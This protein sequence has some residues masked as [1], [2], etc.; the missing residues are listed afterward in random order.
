MT[1]LIQPSSS[2]DSEIESSWVADALL[3][4]NAPDASRTYC[5]YV[6][7]VHFEPRDW[8]LRDAYVSSMAIE[9]FEKAWKWIRSEEWKAYYQ[10]DRTLGEPPINERE[11]LLTVLLDQILKPQPRRKAIEALT[12]APMDASDEQFLKA[13]LLDPASDLPSQSFDILQDLLTTR[14]LS[15]GQYSSA[16]DLDRR[17]MDLV[18]STSSASSSREISDGKV[19]RERRAMIG[20]MIS[21]LPRVQREL[22]EAEKVFEEEDMEDQARGGTSWTNA[23]TSTLTTQQHASSSTDFAPSKRVVSL[24]GLIASS[25]SRNRSSPKAPSAMYQAILQNHANSVKTSDSH[26]LSQSQ[27]RDSRSSTPTAT[28]HSPFVS[29]PQRFTPKAIQ[30]TRHQSPFSS[31][32]KMG[33]TSDSPS[34]RRQ[35][36]IQTSALVDSTPQ[37]QKAQSMSS[38]TDSTPVARHVRNKAPLTHHASESSKLVHTDPDQLSKEEDYDMEV[39]ELALTDETNTQSGQTQSLASES[40]PPRRKKSVRASLGRRGK[41]SEQVTDGRAKAT[42][43]RQVS[44]AESVA[45]SMDQ[46]EDSVDEKIASDLDELEGEE[47]DELATQASQVSSVPTPEPKRSRKRK[48]SSALHEM[49]V[50][51]VIETPSKKAR[52]GKSKAVRSKDFGVET[53]EPSSSVAPPK[54]K[55]TRRTGSKVTPSAPEAELAPPVKRVARRTTRSQSV[56]STGSTDLGDD[57]PEEDQGGRRKLRRSSRLS[58]VA[59]T[60]PTLSVVSEFDTTMGSNNTATVTTAPT[61]RKR[62]TRATS[63][64]PSEPPSSPCP[65]ARRRWS[66]P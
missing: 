41:P 37:R 59:P 46:D 60:S 30:Q 54:K 18:R 11:R 51:V 66:S 39:D 27:N 4:N 36:H 53:P 9:N 26:R 5:R 29:I 32:I 8:Q 28:S 13:Y 7:F 17:V 10:D 52:G 58:S 25:A 38:P 56:L 15:Q 14:Y 48:D 63:R 33:S 43:Q 40:T 23:S 21:L 12:T 19:R 44:A 22:L 45:E 64:Q 61:P 3:N 20:D 55:R 34:Q 42:R 62:T 50:A 65:A 16:I 6:T 24:S 2:P 47:D 1:I 31:P 35:R 49:E 57:A